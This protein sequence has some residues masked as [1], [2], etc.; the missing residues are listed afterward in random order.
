ME[1]CR[2]LV[3]DGGRPPYPVESFENI[4]K[5]PEQYSKLLLPWLEDPDVTLDDINEST[6]PR[7]ARERWRN[8]RVW[9]RTN[10]ELED[11]G[12]LFRVFV[13]EYKRKRRDAYGLGWLT[14]KSG[15]KLTK[16]QMM[17]SLR[18]LWRMHEQGREDEQRKLRTEAGYSLGGLAEYAD[19]VKYR[20]ARNN[21]TRISELDVKLDNDP[22]RQDKL[23]TWI[24]YFD[25][26][27]AWYEHDVRRVER[28]KADRD[29]EWVQLVGTG[30]LRSH[31]T[32][33]DE[34]EAAHPQRQDEEDQAKI[35]VEAAESAAKSVQAWA[36]SASQDPGTS[37][38]E[39]ARR[40]AE[41]KARV[42]TEVANLEL[43][44]SRDRHIRWF[45]RAGLR[46]YA[47]ATRVLEQQTLLMQWTREQI[48]EIE[49]ELNKEQDDKSGSPAMRSAKERQESDED[50]TPSFKATKQ[51]DEETAAIEDREKT[52]TRH[53]RS[54]VATSN[55]RPSKRS[56]EDELGNGTALKHSKR[57]RSAHGEEACE[58]TAAVPSSQRPQAVP[59]RKAC[60]AP[61]PLRRSARIRAREEKSKLLE[62]TT[63]RTN[64]AKTLQGETQAN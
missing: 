55:E 6:V 59:R 30:L 38:E 49:A 9:Q 51:G 47:W 44:K 34:I 5:D 58:A 57:Q 20:L 29:Q 35:A 32:N 2:Q 39:R 33:W 23:T 24:E 25:Y 21:S 11:D 62:D 4:V 13:E 8:F 14:G 12:G 50:E 16:A 40:V 60:P 1:Y 10:R 7:A 15:E 31:E 56:R 45:L 17:K 61:A 42:D 37:E 48:S 18:G 64:L 19:E 36:S 54:E 3:S 26:E 53:V 46:K 28:A 52:E 27:C 41:A 63:S 22:Q 43:I